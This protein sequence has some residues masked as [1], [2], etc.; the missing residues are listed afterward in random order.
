[1]T[2]NSR[3]ILTFSE[4]RANDIARVGGK[5]A[6]LGEMSHA[7]FPVPPGFC[8]T[9]A[10]FEQFMASCADAEGLYALLGRVTTDDVESVR[11]VG[12]SVRKVLLD[13]A[14]PDEIGEAVRQSWLAIGAEHAYAV[15]S[16]ATAEDLP[17]ASFAGQQ[18]TYLNI[19]GEEAMLDAVRRCWV[20]LF[21]DRAIL[22]RV[23][24]RFNHRDV[25]LSVVI[26]QMVMAEKSGILFTA[27]PL[28]G[29]RHTLCI[30]ASFGLG[31]ALVS[32]LVTPDAYKVD[33]RN[34]TIIDRQI[35][36]KKMAIYPEVD[37]GTRQE[38][39]SDVYRKE[40]VLSDP[41]I[42]DLARMAANVE[43]HYGS[44]QDI[45]WAFAEDKFYLLQSRPITSLYPMDGLH[46]ADGS[47]HIFFSMGHQQSMTLP[48]S[49][50]GISNI[51][52][53]L[54]VGHTDNPFDNDFIRSS[55][56]RI[57][58]DLS[59]IL[60]HPVLHRVILR[61]IVLMDALAPQALRQAMRRPEFKGPH[62]LRFSFSAFKALSK[63][64]R[65]MFATMWYRDLNGFVTQINILMDDYVAEVDQS[66]NAAAP[67]KAQMQG[68]VDTLPD[69]F[70]FFLHWVPEAGAGIGATKLLT[71]LAKRWLTPD[72]LEALTLGVP[73]NVVNEMNL[74]IGGLADKAR[75]SAQL[76]DSFERL[77][78]D[79]QAWLKQA[80]K[81]EGSAAFMSA[82]EDF[83]ERYGSRGPSEIDIS[84]ARWY[85]DGLPVLRVVAEFL[86][87]EV[88]RHSAQHQSLIE[89]RQSAMQKLHATAGS[90]L[91]GKLRLGMFNRLYYVMNEVG[92]MRE[93]HKFLM[94]RMLRVI[95]E[96]LKSNAVQLLAKNK[97]GQIDDIW[98]LTWRELVS[99]WDDS[100]T[101]WGSLIAQ[102]RADMA[103]F[104]K[105]KPP[106]IIT[107][108][109][110]VPA[111]HY[112]IDDAPE[113]ALLG[114]PVSP[115]VI[116]GIVHVI[117]D[118]QR[119]TL[120]PGEILVAEFTDP[121]W[122]PLFINAGGLILEIGGALTHGA[123]IA[124][125]YSIP[126][127]VG[128]RDAMSKLKSGQRVRVDGNRGIIEIL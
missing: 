41:Q 3:F 35:A 110:E 104:E 47:L 22:Y 2:T 85:E 93:H 69:F 53:V 128:V 105:L 14:M 46:S 70:P 51:E 61:S 99:I 42:L 55:G 20:S 75:Q 31:E 90:G 113:G 108:D 5:G 124:R 58:A 89:G 52:V 106:L 123:V 18:D 43:D 116:E 15:R 16:S 81:L 79:A 21:T 34:N 54:P 117:R 28:S 26:Q 125:E 10:A 92:G 27:D 119:E 49:P 114:N 111:V 30:D 83:L 29:Q 44:P 19:I 78:D 66:L 59:V 96:I 91:F 84:K 23:Q 6:N 115:G 80:E 13:V 97:L 103:Y 17:D 40:K 127:I 8:L 38:N 9:T 1:M 57:F 74:A 45:E 120:A 68:I 39:L 37:G 33:K 56:G 121:G 87:N 60:L 25:Q 32:G 71:Y 95:K 98:F 24:N 94:V 50:L 122:T 112:Q 86:K 7:G 76:V 126:A 100:A 36:D 82:W 62:G 11:Q 72:E 77:G 64:G 109:G 102:R 65:R 48:M 73:G 4:I 12:Q 118:P 88:G 101:D 67:G 63:Y 107:S